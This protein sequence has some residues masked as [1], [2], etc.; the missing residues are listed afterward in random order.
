MRTNFEWKYCDDKWSSY[1]CKRELVTYV[2][3]SDLTAWVYIDGG[4][5]FLGPNSTS[6]K[7]KTRCRRHYNG[8]ID[9]L[10]GAKK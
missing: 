1:V 5:R 9:T 3:N 6:R 7:A 10:I 2:I 4:H 8:M